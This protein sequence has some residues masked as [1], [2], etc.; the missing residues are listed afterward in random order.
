MR[1]NFDAVASTMAVAVPQPRPNLV[2]N[3]TQFGLRVQIL[4][5]TE[6]N[7]QKARGED[8]HTISIGLGGIAGEVDGTVHGIW[9]MDWYVFFS[10]VGSFVNCGYHKNHAE[11]KPANAKYEHPEVSS[12]T[13]PYTNCRIVTKRSYVEVTRDVE[14]GEE[15]LVDYGGFYDARHF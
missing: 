5:K 15:I 7:R 14:Q 11:S 4:D 12:F 6:A 13:Y 2:P 8:T 9:T 3:L 10:L 1:L